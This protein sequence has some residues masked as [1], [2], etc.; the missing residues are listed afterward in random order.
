MRACN[1]VLAVVPSGVC[2][3]GNTGEMRYLHVQSLPLTM[4]TCPV[5]FKTQAGKALRRLA[6]PIKRKER[7][8]K[9]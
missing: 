1:V 4:P 3:C 2:A 9:K 6:Y 7:T 5:C 8:A